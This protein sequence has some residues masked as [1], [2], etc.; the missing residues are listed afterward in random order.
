VAGTS[1]NKSTSG[2]KPA[3]RFLA[4]STLAGVAFAG[5]ALMTVSA[6]DP[7]SLGWRY[8]LAIGGCFSTGSLS[9]FGVALAIKELM[10]SRKYRTRVI[11]VF[12][13]LGSTITAAAC[14]FG[15]DLLNY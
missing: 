12:Y 4:I 5:L 7:G 2:R 10:S 8:I 13:L 3:I 6:G 1:G 14:L 11:A 9:V 15:Y